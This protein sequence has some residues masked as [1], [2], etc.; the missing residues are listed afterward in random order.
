MQK[1]IFVETAGWFGRCQAASTETKAVDRNKF[2]LV[3]PLPSFPS[4]HFHSLPFAVKLLSQIQLP[5]MGLKALQ[6][7]QSRKQDGVPVTNAF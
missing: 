3:F 7:R 5:A 1:I 6:S 4:F 2:I